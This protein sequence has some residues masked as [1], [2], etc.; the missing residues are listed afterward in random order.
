[1]RTKRLYLALYPIVLAALGVAL[2]W[3][4]GGEAKPADTSQPSV[5]VGRLVDVAPKVPG[6][7]AQTWASLA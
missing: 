7:R 6:S 4:C 3:I 1:M 2:Y 5:T